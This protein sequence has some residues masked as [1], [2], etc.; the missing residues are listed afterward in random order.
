V[1]YDGR[2]EGLH[3]DCITV[4]LTVDHDGRPEGLHC[5]CITVDL[6]VD[7]DGITAGLKARTRLRRSA[8]ARASDWK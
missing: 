1:D 2:P 8:D 3:Y 5:D 7:H 4:D 6:T